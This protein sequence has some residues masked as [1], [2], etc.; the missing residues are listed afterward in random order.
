MPGPQFRPSLAPWRLFGHWQRPPF[1]QTTHFRPRDDLPSSSLRYM[2]VIRYPWPFHWTLQQLH[3]TLCPNL[4]R[5][6]TCRDQAHPRPSH[7][8]CHFRQGLTASRSMFAIPRPLFRTCLLQKSFIPSCRSSWPR[9][10]CRWGSTPV[11]L[12]YP[13]GTAAKP[14]LYSEGAADALP[15]ITASFIQCLFNNVPPFMHAAAPYSDEGMSNID[16][17]SRVLG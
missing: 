9:A 3:P 8:L 11:V 13:Q 2:A 14:L 7:S 16:Q 1:T 17:A 10:A 12:I 15:D 6:F 4:A 5:L